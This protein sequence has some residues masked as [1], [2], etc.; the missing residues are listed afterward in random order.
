MCREWGGECR[1]KRQVASAH[2]DLL[3]RAICLARIVP[4]L[5]SQDIASNNALFPKFA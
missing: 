4:N 5:D 3:E 1:E 2:G